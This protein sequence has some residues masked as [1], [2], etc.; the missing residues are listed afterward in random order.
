MR[1][2]FWLA[3]GLGAGA[4]GAVMAS[5]WM[6][7]QAERL[8]PANLAQQAIAGV[9][10]LGRLA[11]EFLDEFRAGAAV[12]EAEIRASLDADT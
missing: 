1:R 8:A 9:G 10:E 7:R 5:R 12:K 6:K 4:T 2:I 11:G 3:L